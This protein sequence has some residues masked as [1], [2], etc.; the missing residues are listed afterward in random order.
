MVCLLDSGA[1]PTVPL[2][3]WFL[4]RTTDYHKRETET[5]SIET[6]PSN[7]QLTVDP[8]DFPSYYRQFR[9]VP[10]GFRWRHVGLMKS[11]LEFVTL[12]SPTELMNRWNVSEKDLLDIGIA[13]DKYDIQHEMENVLTLDL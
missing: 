9:D 1:D 10:K 5:N 4:N 11:P 12:F 8:N 3:F 6:S 13:V 2:R 7:T